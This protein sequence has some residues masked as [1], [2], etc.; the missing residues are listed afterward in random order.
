MSQG[1]GIA[2]ESTGEAIWMPWQKR[3][4]ASGVSRRRAWMMSARG[5]SEGGVV[6]RPMSSNTRAVRQAVLSAWA[7]VCG[8]MKRPW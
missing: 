7:T 1:S 4:S 2:M 6:A 8:A 3:I 5:S